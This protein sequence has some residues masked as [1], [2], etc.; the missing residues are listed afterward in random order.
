MQYI[1]F[2]TKTTT[3]FIFF[4]FNFTNNTVVTDINISHLW[5]YLPNNQFDM[6]MVHKS[7]DMKKQ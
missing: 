1:I 3:L 4:D 5:Q 7:G 2:N 6:K